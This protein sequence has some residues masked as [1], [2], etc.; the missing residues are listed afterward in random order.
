[1]RFAVF[2]SVGWLLLPWIAAAEAP[3]A[4]PWEGLTFHR[5]P[6]ARAE[7][8]VSEDWPRF[9]GPGDAA[10]SGETHLRKEFPESGPPLVWEC[11]KGSGYASPAIAG[12]KLVL[13]HRVNGL[14]TVECMDAAT[15][16]RFWQHAYAAP[17]SDDFGYSDGPRAGPVIHDGLVY[18]FGVTSWLKC[19]SLESGMVVWEV[20]CGVKYLIPKYFFG[21]GSSPIVYQDLVLLNAGGETGKCVVAF[22][23][24][25]GAEKWVIQHPWGQSYASPIQARWH[26]ADRILFFTG[27]KSEPSTGGLLVIDPVK[28]QLEASFPWRARRYPSVNAASPVLCGENQVLLSHAYVDRDHEQNGS[29]LLRT[30]GEGGLSPVW[31]DA[32]FGCHWMTP[33]YHK[34]HLYAFS[35][36][37]ER[38]CD[39]ICVEAATG[40]RLWSERPT[41][42][43]TAVNDQKIP[44]SFY[45]A[46]LL[47]A[48]GDA[49][50]L[51]L[52]EWGTL[53]WLELS[54]SG[55]KRGSSAQL[56]TAQQSWTLPALSQG[57]LYVLQNEAD[58][59]TGTPPRLLC[60]DLRATP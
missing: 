10:T 34:G 5:A 18:T 16:Q 11:R 26:G 47:K 9:L 19:L 46:S 45:R 40:K 59:I 28:G 14:E 24:K 54:P 33:V 17:Y 8:A 51:C 39:L 52:G 20:D 30:Y 27:G 41:W 55:M 44:M 31:Q 32:R 1:M 48:G 49:Q 56:F 29:V 22:D 60:Y 23:R 38:F 12:G 4:A 2:A 13:F 25:S 15:G 58:R 53:S 43:Y 36:E 7:G 57:L 37:K 42:T 21:S 6:V 3:S 50:F 35:G